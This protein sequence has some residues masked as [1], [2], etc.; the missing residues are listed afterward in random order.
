[1]G[2]NV[3]L[4]ISA[5]TAVATVLQI[6]DQRKKHEP[7]TFLNSWRIILSAI[8]VIIG[9]A[10]FFLSPDDHKTPSIKLYE[11]PKYLQRSGDSIPLAFSIKNYG[12]G[13][14]ENIRQIIVNVIKI[15]TFFALV[16]KLLEDSLET[17]SIPSGGVYSYY[18]NVKPSTL[19]ETVTSYAY[20]KLVYT[21]KSHK[22]EDVWRLVIP[23]PSPAKG[24]IIYDVHEDILK[25]IK[26]CL[27]KNHL[28]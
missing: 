25:Q 27:L 9:V 6:M 4:I 16:G 13:D 22:F 10:Y 3:G 17:L 11:A 28:W 24:T 23:L 26:G 1:M 7:I 20:V 19:S 18:L 2:A 14:A 15:D 5:I 12:S 21:D 8:V